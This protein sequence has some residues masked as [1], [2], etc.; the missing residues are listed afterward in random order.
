MKI[1]FFFGFFNLLI[2][3]TTHSIGHSRI[4]LGWLDI[5]MS[6]RIRKK[7]KHVESYQI[8][9]ALRTTHQKKKK[10]RQESDI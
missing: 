7:T 1:E 2:M 4:C 6:G 10:T 3:C 8:S 9:F 5:Y